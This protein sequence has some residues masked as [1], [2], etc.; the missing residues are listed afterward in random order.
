MSVPSRD[1][2]DGYIS[3]V[4]E[5]V[6]S[7]YAFITDVDAIND[8]VQ[9]LWMHVSRFGPP[10][11]P[12]IRL[13]SLGRFEVPAP[14][15]PPPPLPPTTTWYEDV[16]DW[17]SRNKIL[18]GT[19]CVGAVGA[20]LLA[21]YSASSYARARARARRTQKT[22]GTS[23]NNRRLVVVVLGG[24]APLGPSLI[25]GLVKEGYIVITSVSN[26]DSVAETEATGNGYVRALVFDPTE[27]ATLPAF[28]KSL[29][30]TLSL[31]FPLNAAGDPYQNS[32][33]TFPIIFSV[34]S[35]IT[36]PPLQ[37]CPTPA[38]FEHLEL[39]SS[40]AS[41]L[42]HTHIMPLQAIQALLPLFRVD[43]VRAKD[44][45]YAVGGSRSII[46]C[47]SAADARVGVPY[48]SAQ[49]MSAA[50]TVRGAEV[51]RRELKQVDDA[52]MR[53][54]RVVVVDVGAIGKTDSLGLAA[55]SLDD[56]AL[57]RSIEKWTPGEQRVYSAPYAAFISA[58][59][60]R[61]GRKPQSV[62][63]FV[64]TMVG[65][66]GWN[67]AKSERR[68]TLSV[69]LRLWA[70][71][72]HR[73][74]QGDRFA[75][76]AGARTYAAASYLPSFMLDAL[77]NLPAIVMSARNRYLPVAPRI[78]AGLPEVET[79]QP[80]VE[81]TSKTESEPSVKEVP[82]SPMETSEPERSANTRKSVSDVTSSGV[83][84]SWISVQD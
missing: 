37:I 24:D 3:S 48:A 44:S 43:S 26:P 17:A 80:N 71:G 84:N 30:A 31:R 5:L 73:S 52:Q 20:G 18:V 36:L 46:F 35:L 62:D 19:M 1:Q 16:A 28:L 33:T 7:S 65:T 10:E 63:K 27:P 22:I 66:V 75:V 56:E 70:Y 34:I 2:I 59:T 49:A 50:A 4:E 79:E 25:S 51:L 69:G 54:L 8:S 32:P 67:A 77:L 15:P 72:L 61:R 40:Y 83:D 81:E 39:D 68:S 41:F 58:V 13:P 11:M 55:L 82:A 60:Q 47:V 14:L 9:R 57:S 64:K 21:G 6:V 76:G 23:T 42:S 12:D 38:P 29:K 74:L 78:P 45:M 53:D